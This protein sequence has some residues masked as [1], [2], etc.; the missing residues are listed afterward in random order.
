[1]L[2]EKEASSWALSCSVLQCTYAEFQHINSTSPPASCS[3]D[4]RDRS[5]FFLNSF[6][7]F[8]VFFSA[9]VKCHKQFEE[10]GSLF[11]CF[12][13]PGRNWNEKPLSYH[14]LNA[15]QGFLCFNAHVQKRGSLCE[16]ASSPKW[17]GW[18]IFWKFVTCCKWN[19]HFNL[20]PQL[21]S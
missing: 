17:G 1:M 8:R 16:G 4:Q 12:K 19:S 5:D 10:R 20:C 2:E 7:H 9:N 14:H 11:V 6:V 13:K 3:L 21:N 18:G 15:I